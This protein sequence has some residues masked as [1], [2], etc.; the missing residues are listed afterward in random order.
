M[1][2]IRKMMLIG[3]VRA[4]LKMGGIRKPYVDEQCVNQE[5][6]LT[7]TEKLGVVA[8]GAVTFP[9][10]V[11]LG[12]YNDMRRLEV[13]AFGLDKNKYNTNIGSTWDVIF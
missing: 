4:L 8:L 12:A 6:L 13:Y 5:R 10:V 11:P 1:G 9:V 7:M 2:Y 3:A